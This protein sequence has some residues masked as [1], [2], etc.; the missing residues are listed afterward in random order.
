VNLIMVCRNRSR[1]ESALNEI[2]EKTGNPN[3]D[4]FLMDLS[5]QRAIRNGASEIKKKYNKLDILINN[6]GVLLF[7]KILTE[8]GIESIF[9]VNYLGPFLLTNLLLDIIVAAAPSRIINVV[10][11]GLSKGQL[12]INN[13]AAAKKFNPV[14]I[15]SQAKQAEILFT[16]ELAE[17]LKG[18]KVT[19]NCYYPGLVRTN[20]G[21]AE[22]GF[23]KVTFKIITGLLKFL[24]TPMEESI[25]TGIYLAVSKKAEK[26]TGKFLKR[27][28]NK[29]IV[30][31]NYNKEIYKKLWEMSEKLTGLN[32]HI[33]EGQVVL[34]AG[35]NRPAGR[36]PER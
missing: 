2:K 3:I 34:E 30:K 19:S 26:L 14:K 4:L 27:R 17:R 31:S 18:T 9:A 12:D 13:L 36:M 32:N 35:S 8:D 5:S 16:Y 33:W 7:Q 11:E 10:S 20:L 21:K 29:I 24:F 15:Y 23:R 6:A 25:K 28:K 1:G 22:K